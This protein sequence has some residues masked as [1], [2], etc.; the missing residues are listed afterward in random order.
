MQKG[1]AAPSM[2]YDI[3]PSHSHK[4]E[5]L[6][7]ANIARDRDLVGG[8]PAFEEI[9]KFL[10][11]LEI[12]ESEGILSAVYLLHSEHGETLVCDEFEVLPHI[13]HREPCNAA[14]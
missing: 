12:H 2:N 14:A 4:L 3:R 5:S 11:I 13:D 1:S 6:V 9:G 7:K 8:Y 10:D